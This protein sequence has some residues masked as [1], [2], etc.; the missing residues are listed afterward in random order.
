MKRKKARIPLP[1]LA[2]LISIVTPTELSPM[3]GSL[4]MLPHRVVIL[5]FIIPAMMKLWG[6][7]DRLRAGIYDYLFLLYNVWTTIVFP[8]HMGFLEGLQFGGSLAVESWGGYVIARA[9][10]RDLETFRATVNGLVYTVAFVGLLAIP[11]GISGHHFVHEWLRFLSPLELVVGDEVRWGLTRA[12]S[13]FNHPILYGAYCASMLSLLWFSDKAVGPRI[14][15]AATICIA[16]FFGLSSAPLNTLL[17]QSALG[18]LHRGTKR[19]PNRV[20][21]LGG[22]VLAIYM[23]LLVSS[24]QSPIALIVGKISIDPWTAYY[25]TLIWQYGMDNVWANP[26]L[27]LGLDDWARPGWMISASVDAFW[28]LVPMRMGLPALVLL[29][30]AI[31]TLMAGVHK[32]GP[33]TR[34]HEAQRAAIGWTL[35]F[36]SLALAGLTVHYWDSIHSYIFLVLGMGGWLAN[37]VKATLKA[38]KPKAATA[39]AEAEPQ[40]DPAREQPWIAPWPEPLPA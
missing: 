17:V 9:Y 39:A 21:I 24:N 4:H 14:A 35:C 3:I 19:F 33:R 25:R 37:P 6:G 20:K 31:W 29:I 36:T 27:G 7:K 1:V 40:P 12:Y 11:E 8:I 26:M 28:L 22:F 15:K 2:L 10:I 18:G 5:I 16:T 13:V 38:K 34:I 32:Y 30:A 23:F